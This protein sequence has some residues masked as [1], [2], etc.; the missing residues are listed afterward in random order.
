MWVGVR[1]GWA[2]AVFVVIGVVV[3][4]VIIFVAAP[5]VWNMS[6]SLV[7]VHGSVNVVVVAASSGR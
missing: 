6:K 1:G 2:A 7:S 3:G 4:V 5:G